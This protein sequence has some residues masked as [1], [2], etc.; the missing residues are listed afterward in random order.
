MPKPRK[1]Q[2]RRGKQRILERTEAG[3]DVEN[4]DQ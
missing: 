1:R 3:D 4:A 2:Q